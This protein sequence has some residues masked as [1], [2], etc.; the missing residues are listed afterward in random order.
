MAKQMATVAMEK[1][2]VKNGTA[3]TPYGTLVQNMAR[4][5]VRTRPAC[6]ECVAQG[7]PIPALAQQNVWCEKLCHKHATAKGL[8]DKK[9]KHCRQTQIKK[10]AKEKKKE[11]EAKKTSNTQTAVPTLFQGSWSD[12]VAMTGHHKNAK[13]Q[14][15]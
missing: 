15:E 2:W 10:K 5:R 11:K 14:V 3:F 12:A 6:L 7:L 13:S 1:E 8:Q 4:V 9:G